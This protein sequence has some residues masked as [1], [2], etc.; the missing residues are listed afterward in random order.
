MSNARVSS[1][2]VCCVRQ[3]VLANA[4]ILA[5]RH[6]DLDERENKEE[7]IRWVLIKLVSFLYIDLST[8][9][10]PKILS[11]AGEKSNYFS[12]KESETFILY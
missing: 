7:G 11:L 8:C 2:M 10:V 1:E 4:M 5:P 6:R 12:I 9:I 3:I